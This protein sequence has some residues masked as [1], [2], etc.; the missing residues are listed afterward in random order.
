M[1]V[2]VDQLN[3]STRSYYRI[4]KLPRMITNL[5]KN[6]CLEDQEQVQNPS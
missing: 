1:L 5:A 3:L 2:A 6:N 4:L